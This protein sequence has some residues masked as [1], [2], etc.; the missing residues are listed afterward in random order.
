M[1]KFHRTFKNHF[2][3]NSSYFVSKNGSFI[4]E[5]T[6]SSFRQGHLIFSNG[7]TFVDVSGGDIRDRKVV[8]Q[9]H[10]GMTFTVN[11]WEKIT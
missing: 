7:N 2:T 1:S 8:I 9:N 3:L 11:G 5:M 10:E 6:Y 4:T